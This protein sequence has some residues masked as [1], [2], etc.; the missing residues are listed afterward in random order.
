MSKETKQAGELAAK[1]LNMITITEEQLKKFAPAASDKNISLVTASF[2]QFEDKYQV[3]TPLR[4][5]AFFSQ[6]IHESGNFKYTAEIASGAAYEGR[7]DL[8]NVVAGDGV[9]FR[10]RGLIQTTGRNN[11]KAVGKALHNDE[12]YFINNPEKLE[13][14]PDAMESAFWFWDIHN[15]NELADKGYLQTITKR[16]NGGLNGFAERLTIYNRICDVYSLPH[17]KE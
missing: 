16:I 4:I 8:G 6:L 15:L 9:K 13:Q 2:N 3:N 17:W 1:V 11:Y 5:A 14:Y 7:R 10:G 12:N